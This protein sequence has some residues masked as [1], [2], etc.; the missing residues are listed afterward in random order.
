M[1]LP[2]KWDI[3][4]FLDEFEVPENIREHIKLVTKISVFLAKE[5]IEEGEKID[6]RLVESAAALHDLDK[7]KSDVLMNNHGHISYDFLMQKGFSEE[8]GDLIK[9]HRSE[10]IYPKNMGWELKIL[11]YADSRALGDKLV[12]LD[13]RMEDLKRRY[14]WFANPENSDRVIQM[15]KNI[16]TEIFSKLGFLPEELGAELNKGTIK[17][18][19]FVHGTTTDNEKGLSTGWNPGQL[20]D[21]GKKQSIELREL[22]KGKKFDAIFCSDLQRSIDSA[23]LTFGGL[24]LEDNIK[25]DKRLRECN[26]G[27]M[28]SYPSEHV[29]SFDCINNRFPNGESYKDV[30]QRMKSFLKDVLKQYPNKNI[31]IVA[32]KATQFAL[33]VLLKNKTWAQAI[34]EDWRKTKSWKPGWEY[35]L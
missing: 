17:I 16:E 28:N 32:H 30:E 8:L 35:T 4:K 18:T 3:E 22:I 25:I 14:P 24:I 7:I 31:A 27:D 34:A 12:S 13:E 23:K 10:S 2:E 19:Y 29:E 33:D 6:I 1:I 21:L 15:T 9:Y 26:Y 11:R 5:L 20:S